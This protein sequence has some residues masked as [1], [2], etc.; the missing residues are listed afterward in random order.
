MGS[1]LTVL[2]LFSSNSPRTGWPWVITH[3][4]GVGGRS[5]TSR[6][7]PKPDVQV[8]KHP[9][10]Q[11]FLLNDLQRSFPYGTPD[12]GSGRSSGHL[13]PE[14]VHRFLLVAMHGLYLAGLLRLCGVACVP[15]CRESSL[16][17]VFTRLHQRTP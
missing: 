11:M 9:A 15:R 12:T 2:D 7:N 4:S 3:P 8:S 13:F 6:P 5:F 16:A 17:D 1:A 14:G 10:F